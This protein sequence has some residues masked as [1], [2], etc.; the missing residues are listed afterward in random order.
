MKPWAIWKVRVHILTGCTW[1]VFERSNSSCLLP[2]GASWSI[3]INVLKHCI[4]LGLS[5]GSWIEL[6]WVVLS[7]VLLGSCLFP[8]RASWTFRINVSTLSCV[9]CIGLRELCG[10]DLSC[11]N[12]VKLARDLLARAITICELDTT[13][14]VSG[15]VGVK[16]TL[17]WGK[18]A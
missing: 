17:V 5:K 8:L 2:P 16:S 6:Y 3:R 7:S 10:D 1:I 14:C 11:M 13:R 9:T 4:V 18:A 15:W 12:C